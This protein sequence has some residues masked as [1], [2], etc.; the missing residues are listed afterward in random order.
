MIVGITTIMTVLMTEIIFG[1]QNAVG[2]VARQHRNA[3]PQSHPAP[4]VPTPPSQERHVAH[5]SVDAGNR[6]DNLAAGATGV[7]GLPQLAAEPMA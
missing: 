4:T 5:T 7:S 2:G 6:R 3:G 1:H